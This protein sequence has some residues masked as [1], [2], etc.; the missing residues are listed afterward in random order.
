MRLKDADAL[1][2]RFNE[3]VDSMAECLMDEK[4]AERF[5]IFCKVADAIDAVPTIYA[6]PVVRCKDCKWWV[7]ED[8]TIDLPGGKKSARC[9][10]HNHF[11]HGRHYGWCPKEDDFCSIGE[12]K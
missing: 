12:K 3:K 8:G 9:N 11:V 2:E 10:M 1:L 7:D 5:A 6:V 4:T